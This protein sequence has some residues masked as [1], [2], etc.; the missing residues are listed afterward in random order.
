[1][2]HADD[3]WA[4]FWCS[5][6]APILLDE[7]ETGE[8]GRFLNEPVPTG[9]EAAERST[10]TDLALDASSE[11]AS[12]SQAKSSLD[13][14]GNRAPIVASRVRVDK[15]CS[16]ALLSSRSSNRVGLLRVINEFLKQ[17][18]GRTI[19]KSTLNR[20]LRKAG[21][22]RPQ[23]RRSHAEKIRCRWTRDHSNALWVG[24]FA[25][26]PC[27]FHANQRESSH[28]FRSGSI[29]I[30]ATWS[31]AD[32]TSAKILTSLSILCCVRG[33]VTV[34]PA[35]SMLTTPRFTIRVRSSWL[36]RN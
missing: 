21:A 5:L 7:V 33:Q 34:L 6:L 17:E 22:T 23:A 3:D 9:S 18:Y 12:V 35:R 10:K 1:M 26:G 29:A 14:V 11:S 8:R 32:I 36:V 27:V 4:V 20:H 24:D 19:P 28:I 2:H 13:F 16:S 25:E 31:K 15:P 30:V